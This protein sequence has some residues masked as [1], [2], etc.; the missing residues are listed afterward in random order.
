MRSIFVASFVCFLGAGSAMAQLEY[1]ADWAPNPLP[2]IDINAY[3]QMHYIHD[4]DGEPLYPADYPNLAYIDVNAPSGGT[5][6]QAAVGTFDSFT[7]VLSRGQL[8][9]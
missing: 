1:V 3:P 4:F 8:G 9:A 2:E 5:L 6:R 7:P